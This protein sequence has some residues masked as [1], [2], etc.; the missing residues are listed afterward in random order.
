M[1]IRTLGAVLFVLAQQADAVQGARLCPKCK[2][3]L[4]QVGPD[5]WVCSLDPENC[6]SDIAGFDGANK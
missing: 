1:R 4:I 6:R 5:T 3:K 2:H